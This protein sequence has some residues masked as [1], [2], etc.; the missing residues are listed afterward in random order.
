MVLTADHV[1]LRQACSAVKVN[2]HWHLSADTPEEGC[3]ALSVCWRAGDAHAVARLIPWEAGL[4]IECELE[5]R[6][7]APVSFHGWRPVLVDGERGGALQVGEEPWRASTLINGYQS[8]DYAG[9]HPL[10]DAVKQSD[11][12]HSRQSWWT[13]AIYGPDRNAMFVAQVLR[14]DRFATAFHWRYHRDDPTEQPVPSAISS[15]H[16]EQGGSPV[17]QPEQRSGERQMLSLELPAGGRLMSDPILLLYGEDGTATLQRALRLAGRSSGSRIFPA[18]PRGWCSW[19][20]LGQAVTSTDIRRHAAFVSRRLPQLARSSPTPRR[21]VIQLDD[22]WMPHWGD[23]VP[24]GNFPEGLGPLVRAIRRRR[25]EAGI[26]L[27]PFHADRESKLAATYPGWFLKDGA[28]QP[29]I[30]PRLTHHPYYVLDATH[31]EAMAHLEAVFLNLRRDGFTYF[32]LD[33]LYAAAY[34]AKRYD[35]Q[36]TGTESLRRALKRIF[37]AVNPPGNQDEA[38]VLACGAPIL[39]VVGFVHGN[40]I[41]GD[42]AVP[43]IQDGKVQP[44]AVGFSLVLSMA[45][46]QAARVFFD[47]NLFAND[48]DVAMVTSPQLTADEARV[49]L[50]V[51]ALSGGVFL[52]SDDL[53]TL[54]GERLALLRNPNLLALAGGPAAEPLHLF[55]APELEARDHWYAFPEELPPVWVLAQTGGSLVVATYNWSDQ[56]RP[57]VLRLAELG[58]QAGPF[59]VFDLWSPRLGGRRLGRHSESLRLRL[60]PHSVRLFRMDLVAAA[61]TLV[62][63][64]APS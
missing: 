64:T 10:D 42:V 46:N 50:T 37:E 8:W 2:E 43:M 18:P 6:G 5:N 53:E 38:F 11:G 58:G 34:E 30:D 9:I 39:P 33:F 47:R 48:P 32:K 61:N 21:P 25:L 40:R 17:S 3:D 4:V 60:R 59:E 31:P 15:W 36:A 13:C 26:W 44:P 52:Y 63:A 23:W 19:Y 1:L 35:P 56:P 55:S 22:G 41:G 49:M 27:A 62:P 45:R 24:N 7:P 14:S 29:L 54:P 28:G 57:F 16:A 20:H 12:P 51:A